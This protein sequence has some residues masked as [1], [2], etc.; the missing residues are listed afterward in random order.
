[1]KTALFDIV[2]KMV[3]VMCVKKDEISEGI[4]RVRSCG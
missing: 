3:T 2:M 1:M 4:E